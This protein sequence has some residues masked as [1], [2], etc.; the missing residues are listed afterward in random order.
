[1]FAVGMKNDLGR[2]ERGRDELIMAAAF[3]I[4]KEI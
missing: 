4:R 3:L 1:M 2:V